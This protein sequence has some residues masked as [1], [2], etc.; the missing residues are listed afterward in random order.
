M[1]ASTLRALQ[2]R[3]VAL[4]SRLADLSGVLDAPAGAFEPSETSLLEDGLGESGHVIL[5][6][7]TDTQLAF[8]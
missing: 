6:T 5:S 2:L 8:R 1:S 4:R 3:G 7:G